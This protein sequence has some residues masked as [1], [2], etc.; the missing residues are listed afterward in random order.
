VNSG[1]ILTVTLTV[2]LS[3]S[4]LFNVV[5]QERRIVIQGNHLDLQLGDVHVDDL[6]FMDKEFIKL[7]KLGTPEDVHFEDRFSELYWVYSFE[8]FNLTY[9]DHGDGPV[10]YQLEVHTPT[11]DIQLE[12]VDVTTLH[13]VK[14]DTFGSNNN[15]V[16][17]V[18][19]DA[20]DNKKFGDFIKYIE[21]IIQ[22]DRVTKLIYR[23]DLQI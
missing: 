21:V 18:D 22:N 5:A 17:Q 20:Y 23:Y 9:V 16:I 13:T 3:L 10:L 4:G 19:K 8:N 14:E 11:Q 6:Y 2:V 1:T 15:P 12:G 7:E